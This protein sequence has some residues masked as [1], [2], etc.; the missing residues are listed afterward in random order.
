MSEVYKKRENIKPG[1]AIVAGIFIFFVV[2]KLCG[3]IWWAM[4]AEADGKTF[5]LSTPNVLS[6]IALYAFIGLSLGFA[7]KK[8]SILVDENFF[9][10]ITGG[11]I[12][13]SFVSGLCFS[14]MCIPSAALG[15][16]MFGMKAIITGGFAKLI[17]H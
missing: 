10:L 8:L 17:K 13:I 6:F 14:G 16:S 12:G 4:F 3:L 1:L 9:T 2:I 5:V 11:A 15:T 7:A